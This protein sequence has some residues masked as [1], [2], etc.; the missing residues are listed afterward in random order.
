[1]CGKKILSML[2]SGAL[3]LTL[4]GCITKTGNLKNSTKTDYPKTTEASDSEKIYYTEGSFDGSTYE[5]WWAN[6][7]I[8]LPEG[9]SDADLATHMAVENST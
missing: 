1:M 9:F 8:S 3:L 5:N 7:R 4:S 2:L 6:I